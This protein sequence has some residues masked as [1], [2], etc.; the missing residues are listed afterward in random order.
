MWNIIHFL[1]EECKIM[2]LEKEKEEEKGSD[3]EK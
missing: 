1:K 2:G 3:Q